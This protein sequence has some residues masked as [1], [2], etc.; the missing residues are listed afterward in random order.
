MLKKISFIIPI[1]IILISAN[2]LLFNEEF[3]LNHKT[4][5]SFYEEEIGNIVDYFAGAELNTERYSE[6]EVDHLKDVRQIIHFSF[7]VI[8]IAAFFLVIY[9][10]KIKKEEVKTIL[11][12]GGMITLIITAILSLI[13][14]NFSKAFDLFHMIFFKGDSWILPF[15]STLLQ[16]FPESF[17]L[18]ATIRIFLYITI[19]SLILVL[20][21]LEIK[22][23]KNVRKT[24]T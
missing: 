19:F 24:K 8:L 7:F 5:A 21:G 15:D 17:F 23:R 2:L 10:Y 13:F 4:D 9:F 16:M 6:E 20:L 18:S 1:I 12:Q 22:R 11:I 14:I 3:Y